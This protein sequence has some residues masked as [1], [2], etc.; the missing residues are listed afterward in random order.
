MLLKV[1]EGKKFV[2]CVMS[3]SSVLG[4]K[5]FEHMYNESDCVA[6]TYCMTVLLSTLNINAF[7]EYAVCRVVK[8]SAKACFSTVSVH[9]STLRQIA[10]AALP[11]LN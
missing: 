3:R 8:T 4:L 9:M 1:L 7:N 6:L 10:P 2:Y 11:C 5:A